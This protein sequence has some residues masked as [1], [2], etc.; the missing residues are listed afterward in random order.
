[1]YTL[2][3]MKNLEIIKNTETPRPN[4]RLIVTRG[5]SNSGK[6][7]KAKEWL[8]KDP[9]N[10]RR[11]NRD[12][13]RAASLNIPS[14]VTEEEALITRFQREAVRLHL[15]K[16]RSVIVDDMHLRAKYVR[17]YYNLAKEMDIKLVV[18]EFPI[19][20]HI[21]LERNAARAKLGGLEVP[22]EKLR[23]MYV[24]FTRKGE[25]NKLPNFDLVAAKSSR[26]AIVVEPEIYVPNIDMPKA[27]IV[28]IDGTLTM[29][30][31][32]DRGAFEWAK[33]GL[34]IP[35][36]H[37]IS[38]VR[39]MSDLGYV[40]IVTSGR[41]DASRAETVKWLEKN[42]VPFN[43]LLMRESGDG[44]SDDVV[45]LEIFNREI[46][47]QYNIRA[48]FDDRQRVVRM[49]HAIGLPLFR[50]GDPDSSF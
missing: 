45:K 12:D 43:K 14:Y 25:L 35:N 7:T 42:N 5:I 39:Y 27:I 29:G 13:L 40:V 34:D 31:H 23:E 24:K 17:E 44:M 1:M 19:D 6:S 36:D 8:A 15:G 37:V 28:D 4:A 21:A 41:E 9:V 50:V 47:Q 3:D 16:G 20:L 22:E 10:R 33:V 18:W 38:L 49:W 48:V 30:I 32:P 2:G 26:E 11:V 46:R